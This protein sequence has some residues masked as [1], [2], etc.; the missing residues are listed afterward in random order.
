MLVKKSSKDFHGL[1]PEV[2]KINFG[3]VSLEI[4]FAVAANL[5]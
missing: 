4:S 3:I 2:L 1:I 5:T